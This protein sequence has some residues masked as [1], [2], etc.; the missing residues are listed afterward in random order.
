LVRVDQLILAREGN[1]ATLARYPTYAGA[2][3]LVDQLSGAKLSV[4]TVPTL[5]M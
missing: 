2:Q 4:D 5:A 3:R 1:L